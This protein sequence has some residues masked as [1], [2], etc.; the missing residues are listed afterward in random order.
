MHLQT[1]IKKWIWK[2]SEEKC[3]QILQEIHSMETKTYRTE[4]KWTKS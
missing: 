1:F 2:H 3:N 4:C